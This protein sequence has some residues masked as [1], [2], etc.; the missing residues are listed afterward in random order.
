MKKIIA[1]VVACVSALV[2]LCGCNASGDKSDKN[3]AD[4]EVNQNTSGEVVDN[5]SS[6]ENPVIDKNDLNVKGEVNELLTVDELV[7]FHL[8]GNKYPDNFVFNE[9]S[10]YGRVIESSSSQ[11]DALTLVRNHFTSSNCTTVESRLEVETDLFYGLYVKWEYKSSG[12]EQILYYDEYVVSFKKDVYDAENNKFGIKDKDEIK[13]IL[14]YI[15][16][17]RT[18]NMYGSKVYSCDISL[19]DNKCIYT[20]YLL[21]VCLGDW[22]MQDALGLL[23]K[24]CQ[25]DLA[26]GA[27]TFTLEKVGMVFIDGECTHVYR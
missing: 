4:K 16:Y 1:G 17:S 18:Y 26:T 10:G 7:D 15:C 24:Q 21:S 25:I 8:N 27:T 9:L 11:E 5:N 19:E 13:K 22:G 3:P 2:M 6:G 23:K 20:A 12:S 14:D